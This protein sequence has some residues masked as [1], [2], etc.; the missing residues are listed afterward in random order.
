MTVQKNATA[1]ISIFL[2][3][4]SI[5]RC[6]GCRER[7]DRPPCDAVEDFFDLSARPGPAEVVANLD[8]GVPD[9]EVLH[10]V[11]ALLRLQHFLHLLFSELLS[12]NELQGLSLVR[13]LVEYIFTYRVHFLSIDTNS[14]FSNVSLSCTSVTRNGHGM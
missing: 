2:L 4:A 10:D 3:S 12:V 13:Y 9:G 11:P 5:I 6:G 7:A 1:A 14:N 8:S